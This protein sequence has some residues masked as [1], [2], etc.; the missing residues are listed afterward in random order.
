[1]ISTTYVYIVC[2]VPVLC[3]GPM[4]APMRWQARRRMAVQVSFG[5]RGC[6][7][8]LPTF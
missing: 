1:M 5:A 8:V 7:R 4:A 6:K 2:F 3:A